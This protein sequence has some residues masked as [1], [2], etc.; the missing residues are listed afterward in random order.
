MVDIGV[1]TTLDVTR[2]TGKSNS[3]TS[4]RESGTQTTTRL[5]D[6]TL[7]EV[8][9]LIGVATTDSS[10][11]SAEFSKRQAIAD[12]QGLISSLFRQYSQTAL[13]QI[14]SKQAAAGGYDSTTTQLLAND[15][16]A[17]TI[18]RAA[19]VQQGQISS[20]AAA[21]ST[22]KK[23]AGES[24]ATILQALLGA[25]ETTSLD[26]ALSSNTN[27]SYSG[28]TTKVGGKASFAL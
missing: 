3:A 1:S 5:D 9:R 14:I 16:F 24:V 17:Q 26:K 23:V 12:S 2:S 25:R 13:P 15:A 20:Y 7:R 6:A 18:A 10:N 4:G 8:Q 28:T 22:K 11:A 27:S 19:E 21:E